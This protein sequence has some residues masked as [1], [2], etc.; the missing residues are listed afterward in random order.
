MLLTE[1]QRSIVDAQG[2]LLIV[3]GPGSGKTTVSILK[4]ARIVEQQLRPEQHVLFL[5][6]AR[7]TA[8]RVIEAIDY[9]H[10]LDRNQK[11]RILVETYHAFFWRLLKTHGY[12]VGLPRRLSVLATQ[13]EAIALS[14]IR[15][16]YKAESKLDQAEKDEKQQREQTERERL[17]YEEGRVCFD[18]FAPLAGRILHGSDRI[19]RLVAEMYPCTILDEFQDTNGDQWD[20]VQALGMNSAMIALADP[21]QRI[22]DWIGADPERLNHMRVMFNPT[23]FDLGNENHRSN[24]TEI[25][26]FGDHILRGSFRDGAYIGI[27]VV[28]YEANQNQAFSK[29]ITSTLEARKRLI[30]SGRSRWSIAI[31]V[32]TKRMTR[33]VSDAFRSPP[34]GLPQVHHT[35]LV[36]VE[37]AILGA[38]LIAFLLQQDVNDLHCERVIGIL[39][40]FFRGR[41]GDTP[42]KSDLAEAER[43]IKA[44]SD[45][46]K[47]LSVGRPIRLTSIALPLFEVCGQVRDAVLSGN[48]EADWR[49]V[50][51]ILE[52][53]AC[54]R[55]KIVAEDVRNLRL[56]EKGAQLRQALSQDWRANQGY[57]NAFEIVRQTFVREHFAMDH[58]PETGVVVMNMHKAKGKQFDEVIIFDGWPH[59]VKRRIVSNPNRI[60]RANARENDDDQARQNFR[61]SV[62]RGKLRTTILTPRVNPCIILSGQ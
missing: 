42:S 32:P 40:D 35:A 12:L 44:H 36:E 46:V 27:D 49:T 16:Q 7:P 51:E 38:E 17:A 33:F 5:S 13:N 28:F 9:E 45:Y 34:G 60:V 20:V 43:L 26:L 37:A 11:R 24:G 47:R 15:S 57:R 30:E 4:A 41:G 10:Q 18:L 19:R 14:P 61:V 25:C 58:R 48:P 53:G 59:I 62:T 54:S 29:L 8:A 23:E 50:R 2:H 21:K 56:L 6:F 22:Y 55:L 52:K 3:G 31:L 1:V 39:C